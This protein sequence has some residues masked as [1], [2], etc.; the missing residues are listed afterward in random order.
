MCLYLMRDIVSPLSGF[1]SPFGRRRGLLTSTA[2]ARLLFSTDEPGFFYDFDD[3]S[4]LFQ[5]NAG[6]I[7]VTA[8]NQGVALALDKS[9]GLKLGPEM[10]NPALVGT[11]ITL[12]GDGEFTAQ[13]LVP[14]DTVTAGAYLVECDVVI[15]TGRLRFQIGGPSGSVFRTAPEFTGGPLKF[16]LRTQIDNPPNFIVFNDPT[17]APIDADILNLTIKKIKGNP[18]T[19]VTTAARPLTAVHPDGGVRNLLDG[20]THALAPNLGLAGMTISAG[21]GPSGEDRL[22]TYNGTGETTFLRFANRSGGVENT[23]SFEVKADG[24]DFFAVGFSNSAGANALF[25]LAAGTVHTPPVTSENSAAIATLGDG[26]YRCSYTYSGIGSVVFIW[27]STTAV[28]P[29]GNT[30]MTT[31]DGVAGVLIRSRQ[32]ELGGTTTAHQRVKSFLDVTEA[33]KRSIRRLYFNG[34]SHFME[35]PVITPNTDKVQVFAGV[36]KLSDDGNGVIFNI[37]SVLAGSALLSAPYQI[38]SDLHYFSI[39]GD[40]STRSASTGDAA[41]SAPNTVVQTGLG[42]QSGPLTALRLNGASVDISTL[43]PGTG[44]FAA[45][46]VNIGRR[47]AGDRYFNGFLDQLITRFGPNLDTATIE[48]TEKYVSTKVPEVETL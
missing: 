36:R 26:W 21:S 24:A 25:D 41:F 33:G 31:G 11:V 5:D 3:W 2:I 18:A 4:T 40:G 48:K 29:S 15:R 7:P 13:P 6:T 23:L 28:S 47:T 17:S 38:V 37:N 10:L 34:T 45:G 22:I 14:L 20:D 27:C 30:T 9:R 16:F 32:Q 1:G 43:S 35:T 39:R 12:V 42:D 19:Q 44:G 8:P 46:V